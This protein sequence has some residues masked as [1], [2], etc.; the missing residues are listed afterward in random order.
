MRIRLLAWLVLSAAFS[1]ASFISASD[2]KNIYDNIAASSDHTILLSALTETRQSAVLKEKG[3]NTFFAPNDEAF[4]KLDEGQL[5]K[6]IANKDL[7]KKIV[8]AHLVKDV[9]LTSEKLK[10]P[11][12]DEVNGFK[13]STKDGLKI[14][15]AKII[16]ADQKCSNG[17][18]HVIDTVLIPK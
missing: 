16:K 15:D 10:A 2:Q 1:F 13:I 12:R 8:L 18:F 3:A 14:G 6:M 9:E 17:I 4:K 11:D 7:L 5:K